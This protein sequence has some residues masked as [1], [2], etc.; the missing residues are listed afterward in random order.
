MAQHLLSIADLG[1][2]GLEEMLN[3]YPELKEEDLM[4]EEGML[5]QLFWRDCLSVDELEP[6]EDAGYPLQA[7]W[8]KHQNRLETIREEFHRRKRQF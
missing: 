7:L 5:G 2:D 3:L 4:I 6:D 8:K 1:R